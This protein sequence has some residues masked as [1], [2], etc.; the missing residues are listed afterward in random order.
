MSRFALISAVV[1]AS[2]PRLAAAD[3]M[4]MPLSAQVVT[5]AGA[6]IPKD[7][8]ILV[9]TMYGGREP[10]P[11]HED[12]VRADW[13]LRGKSLTAP[14]IELYAPG[15]AVY[16]VAFGGAAAAELENDAHEVVA[17]VKPSTAKLAAVPAPKV[18]SVVFSQTLSRH[19][20]QAATATLTADPPVG[21][22]ALVLVDARGK[23]T[24]WGGVAVGRTQS[25][26]EHNDCAML[27]NGTSAPNAGETVTMFWVMDDGRRSPASKPVKVTGKAI[28]GEP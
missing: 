13:R 15:L 9:A 24:S 28:A 21:A 1:L 2:S 10:T 26:Y 6:E 19:S 3:C 11:K 22:M 27:P 7:G 4:S 5:M 14:K 23:A 17:T 25:P 20:R 12:P 8:G 16:R 18:K